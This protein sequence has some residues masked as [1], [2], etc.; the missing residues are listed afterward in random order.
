MSVLCTSLSPDVA[1]SSLCDP[2]ASS[3]S[4]NMIAGAFSFASMNISL[5]S[6]AP[7]PI[8]F[9]TSSDPITLIKVAFVSCATARAHKVLPVP[10]RPVNNT[11]F[12][13]SIPTFSNNSGSSNGSS[14]VS[15]ISSNC[16]LRPPISA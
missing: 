11:P 14:T 12:G 4:M 15:L 8:N 2:T 6:L 3:S 9:C 16:C 1:I 5:T 7:S 13:G 10:G